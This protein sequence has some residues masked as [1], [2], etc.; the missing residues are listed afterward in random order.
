MSYGACTALGEIGR[1]GSLPLV[2]ENSDDKKAVTKLSIIDN[3]IAEVQSTKE[4]GKVRKF[5]MIIILFKCNS[6]ELAEHNSFWNFVLI[7]IFARFER[8]LQ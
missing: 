8:K 5:S 4:N 6:N 1:C 2:N 7:T 3:L